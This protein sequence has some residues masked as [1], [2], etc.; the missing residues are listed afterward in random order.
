MHNR[1]LGVLLVLGLALAA[2]AGP[3]A[4][5]P[6]SAPLA[7][8]DW[9][10][11]TDPMGLAQAAG[12]TPET[13]EYLTTHTHAHLDIFVDGQRVKVPSAIG[14]DTAGSAIQAEL[15]G[16]GS[17]TE[18]YLHGGTC[19]APCLSPLH[20]H[21]STGI[22]HT[23]SREENADPFT[24][25]QFFISWGVALDENCVGEFCGPDVLIS[26]YLN[27]KYQTGDPREIKLQ[28]HDVLVIAIGRPPT[29]IP[30]DWIWGEDP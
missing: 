12:I 3:P 15:S 26:V 24:L 2:C 14:V 22:L 30:Q 5:D 1:P 17:E 28:S 16:D 11:P 13:E 23:E 19:D 20:T 29:Q 8:P 27:G 4:Y 7:Q 9:P 25:G 10:A 6:S 21:D 18:Y